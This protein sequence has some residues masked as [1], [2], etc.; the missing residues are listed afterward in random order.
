MVRGLELVLAIATAAGTAL[1]VSLALREPVVAGQPAGATGEE[2]AQLRTEL[3]QLRVELDRAQRSSGPAAAPARGLAPE[4]IEET[5]RRV[6]AEVL[7]PGIHAPDGAAAVPADFDLERTFAELKD[8]DPWSES[9][10]WKRVHDAGKL[11]E[12]IARFQ[13]HA[14]ENA[15]VP[16]AQVAL[17]TA[18][19]AQ[20]DYEPAK[21]QL[22]LEAD[23]CFDRALELEPTHWQARFT[24]AVSYTFWP[25]FLG[26]KQE[27][28]AHFEQLVAQQERGP[29]QPHYADI[30]LYLGNLLEQRGDAD[31]A[32][33]TWQQGAR[34]HPAHQELAA[35]LRSR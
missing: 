13:R 23:R 26:K 6:L 27:A 7:Q 24:K 3:A 15:M 21:W 25:D 20:L 22:A 28:I 35:K 8:S 12:L 1:L 10:R 16:D 30:Y 11:D 19:L 31:A 18:Y 9:E 2:L 17:A 34:L 29:Q 4:A 14:Q 32:R 33:K 5:V